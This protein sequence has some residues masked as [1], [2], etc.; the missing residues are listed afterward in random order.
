MIEIRLTTGVPLKLP[1]WAR[2][3]ISSVAS[4]TGKVYRNLINCGLMKSLRYTLPHRR[5][6]W[7]FGAVAAACIV[8][9]MSVLVAQFGSNPFI[10]KP[11]SAQSPPRPGRFYMV[12]EG[13]TIV[14]C[15]LKAEGDVRGM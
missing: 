8:L 9:P 3:A 13:A 4:H 12:A 6:T 1:N 5:Q 15:L 10:Q 11:P 7:H 2:N 14:P